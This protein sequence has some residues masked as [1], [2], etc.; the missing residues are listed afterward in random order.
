VTAR[1]AL[2]IL[3]AGVV[4]ALGVGVHGNFPLSDDWAYA[5]TARSLCTT[6]SFEF[7]PW[8]G[9][10]VVAQAGYGALICKLVGFSFT[11][12]RISTVVIA[13]VGA[14]GFA[15]LLDLLGVGRETKALAVAGFALSPLYVNLAFTFMT[16]V[17]FAVLAVWA[18]YFY[19]RALGGAGRMHLLAGALVASVSVLVR[20]Q[21]VFV[22]AA[23]GVAFLLATDGRLA[24]R[25]ADA[26]IAAGAPAATLAG[27]YVWLFA[28]HG[29]PA[30]ASNKLVEMSALDPVAAANIGFRAVE[31]LGLLLI[32]VTAAAARTTLQSQ[33]KVVAGAFALLTG[34]AVFLYARE[35]ALVPYL[36]NVMY[37]FGLG[38][39]SLR[40]VLFLGFDPPD[41]LGTWPRAALSVAATVSAALAIG[42]FVQEA[43][44]A[45]R[46]EA[47]FT[48]AAATLLLAGSF[49]HLQFYFD[50]Y[51][52]PVLPF[53]LASVA[54]T[55]PRIHIGI[56]PILLTLVM[57]WY[58]VAGT[59]DYLAWNRARHDGLGRLAEASVPPEQID[60]GMEYNGWLLAAK[61]GTWPTAEGARPGQPA[62]D[63]S[64]WWVVDDRYVASFWPL[65]GYRIKYEIPYT[66]WLGSRT[67]AVLIQERITGPEASDAAG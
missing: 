60:G 36:T 35:R 53:A 58:S 40:D 46:P 11:A 47:L 9:A 7:L 44:S 56:L 49:L 27:F 1:G 25:L 31:T 33:S 48:V 57:T 17:P 37:D 30:A 21:G 23:A 28:F 4:L 8:T 59:H 22:G 43:R 12:L 63:R 65:V 42:A 41:R 45:R 6:G 34:A 66:R 3:L 18:S 16:D 15:L 5:H 61:L 55:V 64:W 52:L 39:L 2:A 24:R 67:G 14:I 26:T 50:R 20:Q 32:P 38:A 29:A 51:L 13:V 19:A 54:L 10:S 62:T